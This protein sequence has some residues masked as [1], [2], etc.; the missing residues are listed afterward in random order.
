MKSKEAKESTIE[1]KGAPVEERKEEQK[2]AEAPIKTTEIKYEYR[3]QKVPMLLG[4]FPTKG[5]DGA[6]KEFIS[7]GLKVLADH[8][9]T[10]ESLK[11][12]AQDITKGISKLKFVEEPVVM[13]YHVGEDK[14]RA[15]SEYVKNFSN[16]K[17][18]DLEL[19][20]LIVIPDKIVIAL[21]N[22][23]YTPVKVYEGYPHMTLMKGDSNLKLSAA[24]LNKIFAKGQSL[25]ALYH[26]KD[27]FTQAKLVEKIVIELIENS[28]TVYI[29]KGEK[30]RTVSAETGSRNRMPN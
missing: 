26:S 25:N 16:D 14:D 8:F 23:D 10:D 19:A 29:V 12:F 5:S 20:A 4:I 21:C 30:N 13:A 9:K 6:L 11:N 15:K 2:L 27:L 7:S 22:P 18:V 17:K 1:Q 3:R 28:E 24:I